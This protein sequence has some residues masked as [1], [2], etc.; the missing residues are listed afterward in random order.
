MFSWILLREF[1]KYIMLRSGVSFD[2]ITEASAIT[3]GALKLFL[4]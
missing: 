3:R 1:A 4:C 2:T